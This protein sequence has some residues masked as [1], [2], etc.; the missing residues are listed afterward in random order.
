MRKKIIFP[1][2]YKNANSP[3][4]LELIPKIDFFKNKTSPIITVEKSTHDKVNVY[5][6]RAIKNN[7][8]TEKP[9][10][11]YKRI[12]K[13]PVLQPNAAVLLLF[14]KNKNQENSIAFIERADRGSHAGELAFPGGKLDSNETLE[15]CALRETEEEIFIPRSGITILNQIPSVVT[16]TT[17]KKVKP[18]VGTFDR[19]SLNSWSFQTSE[20]KQVIEVS[21]KDIIEHFEERGSFLFR[22]ND[23][24]THECKFQNYQLKSCLTVFGPVFHISEDMKLHGH[25]EGTIWGMTARILTYFLKELE[26]NL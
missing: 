23:E 15:E 13:E 14:F 16:V 22:H 18:F 24:H 10:H 1:K 2:L 25:K 4:L 21:L 8:P 17:K 9:I 12:L 7:K 5:D 20:V 11:S 3:K 6:N 19:N 26:E